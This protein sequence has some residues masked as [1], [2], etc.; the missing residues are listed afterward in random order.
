MDDAPTPSREE[1]PERKKL[2]QLIP[3]SGII[4]LFEGP[5]NELDPEEGPTTESDVIA[6]GL[7]SDGSVSGLEIREGRIVDCMTD[8]SFRDFRE[9]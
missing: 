9:K 4:A 2:I 3:A 5:V 8:K 7:Y 6:L 1:P